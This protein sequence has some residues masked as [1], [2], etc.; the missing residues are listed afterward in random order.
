MRCSVYCAASLDGFIAKLD[1]DVDW[2]HKQEYSQSPMKGLVYDEFISTVDALVMGRRTF[3]KAL[4]FSKWPY[5]GTPVVVLSNR[6][7]QIPPELKGKVRAE[8]GTPR[9]IVSTLEAKGMR[10]LYIDGGKTLQG[11]LQARC[12][13]E[14]MITII[15]VLL[16]AGIPLFGSLGVEVPLRLVSVTPSENGFVQVRYEV[17]GG[18]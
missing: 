18:T 6:P 15:P 7:L 3:E 12:I 9:E 2:L 14:L 4:S 16:G 8:A 17:M 1:D 10:H 13:Q 11:F 5:E